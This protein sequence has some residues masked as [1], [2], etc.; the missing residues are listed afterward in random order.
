M[1]LINTSLAGNSVAGGPGGAGTAAAQDGESGQGKQPTI[2]NRGGAVTTLN[3]SCKGEQATDIATPSARS[4][5]GT[6]LPD[7]ILGDDGKNTLKGKGGKDRICAGKGGDTV[8]G[9]GD[10]DSLYGEGGKDKLKGGG[11]N[12]DLCNGGKGKD[13]AARSC[14]SRRRSGRT[15]PPSRPRDDRPDRRCPGLAPELA[16]L[17]STQ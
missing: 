12:G 11:G 9:G 17:T 5:T 15:P 8:S 16:L 7:V 6:S 3:G 10:K 4:I 1:T 2:Y 13:E 14:R